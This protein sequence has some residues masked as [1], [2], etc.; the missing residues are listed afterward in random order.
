MPH[1]F[2]NRERLHNIVMQDG[3]LRSEFRW[4]SINAT[5]YQAGG[6]LFM[7]GSVCFFPAM[8]AWGDVGAWIF[9]VGSLLYLLVTGHDM[10]EVVR[11]MR[12]HDRSPTVW[13]RLE[14]G[15]AFCYLVGTVLF[16]L[17]SVFFL[18][19]IDMTAAGAWCFVSGSG[20]FVV[21]AVINVLQIMREDNIL[22]LQCMN[23]TALT[24]VVGSVIFILASIPY[25]WELSSTQDKRTIDNFLAW[26]FLVGSALFFFGGLFNYWR[27]YLVVQRA[28]AK[29]AAG[30]A[31]PFSA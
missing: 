15:A 8:A 6:V 20:L 9:F 2:T 17:G 7:A 16:L 12:R 1:L 4:E 3:D 13:T 19:N 5:A 29:H 21:G 18:S 28:R 11:H 22:I 14:A 31:P 26:Q 24:F 10:A 30:A 25:L 23:L 27:A